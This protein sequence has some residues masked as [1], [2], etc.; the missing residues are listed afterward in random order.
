MVQNFFLTKSY[1][2]IIITSDDITA[3]NITQELNIKPSRYFLKN[4]TVSSKHSNRTKKREYNLWAVN[5]KLITSEKENFSS[6]IVELKKL[7]KE[8]IDVLK[9]Y[10]SHPRIKIC[11]WIWI[12]T[13]NSGIGIE[14]SSDEILFLNKIS[15][16]IHISLLTNQN[17]QNTLNT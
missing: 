7:F 6:H 13:E 11:C 1:F 2:E 5:T 10:K 15:N 3:D 9:M 8:K 12:E 16:S 14:L 17:L 4:D